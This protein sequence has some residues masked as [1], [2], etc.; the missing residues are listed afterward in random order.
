MWMNLLVIVIVG[1]LTYLWVTRGFFSALINLICILVAGAIGFAFWEPTS[2]FL[3]SKAPRTGFAS[4]LWQSSWAFG[5]AIPFGI[6]FML[7]RAVLDKLL[8][9]NT[10]L[11]PAADFAGGGICGLGSG[12]ITAGMVVLCLGMLRVDTAFLGYSRMSQQGGNTQSTSGLWIPV[13]DLVATLYGKA[14]VGVF[15]T[16]DAL[17]LYYPNVA[18]VPE[19]L[20]SSEGGGKAM[21][22]MLPASAQVVRRYRVGADGTNLNELIGPDQFENREQQVADFQGERFP[23]NSTLQG[24]TVQFAPG[25]REK[26]GQVV[27]GQ[28]QVRLLVH[29]ADEL[30][31]PVAKDLFPVAAVSLAGATPIRYGRWRFDAPNIFISSVGGASEILFSFEF[32]VP[33][34]FEPVGLY[35]K[36][37]RYDI[38]TQSAAFRESG[39]TAFRSFSSVMQRDMSIP[40]GDLIGEVIR[41]TDDEL[42]ALERENDPE[43][44]D[45]NAP[46]ETG[47]LTRNSIVQ[48]VVQ[49][50]THAGLEIDANRRIVQGMA[51]FEE[52]ALQGRGLDAQLRINQFQ[53][54]ADDTAIVQVNVSVGAPNE[55]L[56]AVDEGARPTDRVQLVDTFGNRYDPVGY[57]YKERTL[58]RISYFP[59]AP[60][61]A[62]RD[63]PELSRSNSQQEL[64]LIYRVSAPTT[65]A[66]FEVGDIVVKSFM[67]S[68]IPVETQN[69]R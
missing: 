6:S 49:K 31:N 42:E 20:R 43:D 58:V 32:V 27:I 10:V 16:S 18:D 68:P 47:I 66:S 8:P 23:A 17:A 34:N 19:M 56:R 40:N 15:S 5:L 65:L 57:V 67:E 53:N 12:L 62:L 59:G 11:E 41:Y 13:D 35:I 52:G 44:V 64:H 39:G 22:V 36:G 25:A 55:I 9:S 61:T 3:I 29:G 54:P 50:G 21:N 63:L 60:I 2:L 51:T 30:G 4:F 26:N 7:L 14:S 45:P 28:N 48:Y 37:V 1:A 69:R 46:P 38:D 24:F 33:P